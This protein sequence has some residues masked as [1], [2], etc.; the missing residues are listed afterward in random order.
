[1]RLP[2]PL[3]AVLP[4]ALAPLLGVSFF[5]CTASD[6]DPPA[7]PPEATSRTAEAYTGD[8]LQQYS[9]ACDQTIGLTVPKID[10]DNAGITIPIT[11]DGA[12]VIGPPGTTVAVRPPRRVQRRVR[13]GPEARAARDRE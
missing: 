9:Q 5:A 2:R 1:M 4:A 3:A 10:C 13:D 12:I 6:G 8:A 11:N 7:R